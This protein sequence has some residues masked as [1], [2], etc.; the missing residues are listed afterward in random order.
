MLALGAHEALDRTAVAF[1]DA[2]D[3]I[4]LVFDTVGGDVLARSA[5]IL[6]EGGRIV[7]VAEEP[8]PALAETAEAIYFVVEPSGDQRQSSRGSPTTARSGR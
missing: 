3:G 8:P 4:D 5:A 2:I 7:S 1:E 6:G